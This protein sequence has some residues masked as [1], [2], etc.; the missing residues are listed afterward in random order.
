[1][2]LLHTLTL[3]LS[4]SAFYSQAAP[5]KTGYFIDSPVTG[6]YYKTSSNL[7]GTTHK[8]AFQYHPGDVVS[9]FLGNDDSG[10]L[11]TT[12]SGQEVITPTLASTKPSRSI[13]MTRLLLS[14][15]STPE[16]R[17]EIVLLNKL[18]SDPKLQQQLQGLDLNFLDSSANQLDVELVSVKEAVE[19]LN[20]SQRYIEQHFTSEEVIFSPLNVRLRN[21]IIN[22]K[23]WQGRAC[24]LDLRHL[25]RPDYRTPVGVMS[26]EVTHDSL[27][28]YPSV[29]DYFNGCYLNRQHA[30][31]E[32]TVEPL[33]HFEQW[34]GVVGCA[35]QGCTRH[36]LNGFSLEDFDDEGDWKYRSVAL[37]FDPQTQL[38]MG[39][40]QGLGRKAQV[41]HS[42]KAESLWFTYPEAK[43]QHIAYEGIWKETQ[44]QE[45]TLTERCLN[46]ADGRVWLGPSN[47]SSCPLAASAYR[48]D[49]TQEYQDMWWLRNASGHAQ[50][51][52]M[53]LMVRWFP[54]PYP[55]QYTTWEY[56]PAGQNWDQGILYRYQQQ[57]SPQRD[58]SD[59]ID[60]Y[61]ISEFVKQQGEP[62]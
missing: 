34:E 58:G 4:L 37:N 38:L 56:L 55:A 17:D 22:K 20:Q 19:H 41:A 33:S 1:M 9:F 36:D 18:L 59:R 10:Y 25:D 31:R 2:K 11:L 44:Y 16:N 43:G 12:L 23:D 50:L 35:S 8:G 47:V 30:Y 42:N 6:L 24:A 49:V 3:C 15:D 39:K 51:E 14:L 53:N 40:M 61:T 52:Q 54:Q 13:N 57:V 26:F 45:Q 28:Q 48:Q 27:I 62:S 5:P 29:G 46:I 7:S 32:K 21:I 60:T